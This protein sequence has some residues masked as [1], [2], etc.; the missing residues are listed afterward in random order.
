MALDLAK[1]NEKLTLS[2][3]KQRIASIKAQ[4]GCVLD[5]SGSMNHLYSN[6]TM[7]EYANRMVPLGLRFDDNGQID[8]WAFTTSA[9]PTPS[10]TAANVETFVRDN[11]QKISAGGTSF[12]PV[13]SAII[14]HYFGAAALGSP[15]VKPGL[16]GGLFGAKST[17][18]VAPVFRPVS[19]PVYLIFQTDGENDDPSKTDS[20]LAS[21]E[22]QG[23]YIQF[24]GVGIAGFSFLRKMADKYS[25][26]GFFKVENLAATSEE[27][28]YDLL[29]NAEFKTFLKTRFPASIREL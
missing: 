21:L 24:V 1:R 20:L 13:L 22:R 5:R 19:D 4:V 12:F 15:E 28:L 26:V 18:A 6:G 25:N 7:Q 14:A 10:I 23:I 9:F 3:A 8:S 11:I 27:T 16:L 29:I 2:L 17:P